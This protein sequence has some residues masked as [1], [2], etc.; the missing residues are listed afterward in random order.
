[1]VNAEAARITVRAEAGES[2]SLV[3]DRDAP[4]PPGEGPG[5]GWRIE[6][7]LDWEHAEA[8]RLVSAVFDDGRALALAALRP[9]GA[10]GHDRD[11]V[12]QH[13]ERSGEE[14]AVAEALMSTEYDPDGLARRIGVELWVEPDSPPLR[15]AAD[16]EGE[17]E[18]TGDGIRREIARMSFRLEGVEGTGVYELLRPT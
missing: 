4:E 1:M 17:L 10:S 5:S 13:F 11:S 7:E 18:I 2:L 6:G 14:I 3:W 8:L 16:R 15:V 12:A 9:K